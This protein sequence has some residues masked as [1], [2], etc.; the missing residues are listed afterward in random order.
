MAYRKEKQE[1]TPW[2]LKTTVFMLVFS[3]YTNMVKGNTIE[4][5]QQGNQDPLNI[6][7]IQYIENSLSDSVN[8]KKMYADSNKMVQH[9]DCENPENLEAYSLTEVNDW[10]IKKNDI[11]SEDAY[12]LTL[13]KKYST[14]VTA[15]T[16]EVHYQFKRWWCSAY[17]SYSRIEGT[18]N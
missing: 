14:T 4:N 12:V 5:I 16:C 10:E 1:L 6:D 15:Y 13:Q 17:Q 11:T 7:K 18:H 8:E 3:V 9:Y 2:I